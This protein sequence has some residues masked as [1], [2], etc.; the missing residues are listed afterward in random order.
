MNHLHNSKNRNK[1]EKNTLPN[2]WRIE[3]PIQFSKITT[4]NKDTQ[5][6]VSDGKY[7]FYVRSKKVEKINSFSYDGVAILTVG[8]GVGTRQSLPLCRRKI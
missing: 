1:K 8:D 7:P 3:Y 5:D 4:G 6:K 2:E